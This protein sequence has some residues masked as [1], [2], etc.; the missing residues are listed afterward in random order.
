MLQKSKVSVANFTFLTTF[1][2][3]S[4]IYYLEKN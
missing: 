4:D 3:K 1:N 2:H